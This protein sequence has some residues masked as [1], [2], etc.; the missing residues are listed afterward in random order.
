MCSSCGSLL[1]ELVYQWY[2]EHA[3]TKPPTIDRVSTPESAV[4]AF[5][6]RG[7]Y[8]M[9]IALSRMAASS[10]LLSDI[11]RIRPS[12]PIALVALTPSELTASNKM[13]SL[14]TTPNPL[15][16]PHPYWYPH[17]HS[18][19]PRVRCSR[20]PRLNTLPALSTASMP[21]SHRVACA[22]C[23]CTVP[24]H[25]QVDESMR[26]N[27]N[28][29]LLWEDGQL[30]KDGAAIADAPSG[31]L[32]RDSWIWPFMW[33]GSPSLFTAIFKA[34]EDR[35]NAAHD[36]EYG[37]GTLMVIEDSV[38]FYSSYLPLLYSELWRQ[39]Q[40]IEGETMQT[41][42]RILRMHSRP[43]VDD[44]T[45][46]QSA[47]HHI[48]LI[49][50]HVSSPSLRMPARPKVLFCTNY[51]EA[52]DVYD[53]YRDTMFGVISDM[54]FPKV[55]HLP[56]ISP[57]T[58][59]YLPIPRHSSSHLPTS[60]HM[61]SRRTACIWT[62]QASSSLLTSRSSSPSCRASCRHVIS[63]ISHI[64][65]ISP[66]L[67]T[68]PHISHI[69]PPPSM[70]FADRLVE[71]PCLIQSASASDTPQADAA[72]GLGAKFVCKSSTTLLS[73]LREF[74][75]D[76]LMF[77]PLKFQVRPPAIC[78]QISPHLPLG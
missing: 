61:S 69:S 15:P 36:V 60:P 30:H 58:T 23:L 4:E 28:K 7:D 55:C 57:H 25:C 29:R 67:P 43:K 11:L 44:L 70:S 50:P 5:R 6:D 37:V 51:E 10:N 2:N 20:R 8:D 48:S 71:L 35:L 38:K 32:G 74:M 33:H 17:P 41:R 47:A 68:S 13:V 78:A 64:S 16:I 66:H 18:H 42:E 75:H 24:V 77:G 63:H 54:A 34:V 62:Q 72:R 46:S 27:V 49:S 19:P 65:H 56:H 73:E 76:D 31:S 40:L 22:L 9:V 39:N 45:R 26:L 21:S 14:K 1:S 12:T 52:I 53:R 3:L 59:R